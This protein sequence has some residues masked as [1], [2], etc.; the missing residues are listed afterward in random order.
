[1]I[2]L[3]D[4]HNARRQQRGAGFIVAGIRSPEPYAWPQGFKPSAQTD[5]NSR[6]RPVREKRS[7]ASQ[8]STKP[9]NDELTRFLAFW[10]KLAAPAQA[11]FERQALA[12]ADAHKRRWFDEARREGRETANYFRLAILN[13]HFRR[14]VAPSRRKNLPTSRPSGRFSP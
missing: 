5:E 10:D 11:D 13:D 14:V 1:M 8:P 4:W 6:I 3:H 12:Q 2:D 9:P 7:E